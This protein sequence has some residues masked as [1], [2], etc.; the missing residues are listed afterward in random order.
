MRKFTLNRQQIVLE[1]AAKKEKNSLRENYTCLTSVAE[2]RTG[3]R[4]SS[5]RF[6]PSGDR[7]RQISLLTS[8]ALP[9]VERVLKPSDQHMRTNVMPQ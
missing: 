2:T 1:P 3:S 6:T 9:K 8:K 7:F 4:S 5:G